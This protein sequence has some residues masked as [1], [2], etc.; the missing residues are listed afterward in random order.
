MIE[1]FRSAAKIRPLSDLLQ[2]MI[3]TTRYV[4]VLEGEN[5]LEAKA[6][7][8]NIR[9]FLI[10]VKEFEESLKGHEPCAVLQAYLEFISLQTQI[11]EWYEGDQIFTLMTLHSAKGLEFPVVFMLGVEE[12]LLPHINAMNASVDEIEEERRLCY[13]GFTR[14]K[15]RLY[16]SYAVSRRM[17]G[18]TKRQHPSR[19]LYEIPSKLLNRPPD[20]FFASTSVE[21]GDDD[22]W[23]GKIKTA[24]GYY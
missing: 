10:S 19:F 14:A 21:Y 22:G 8:E 12:G 15:E 13:V 1:D 9:E 4:V 2:S 6:R 17:F 3:D 7:V 11:D 20:Y 18:Y 24:P 5:T 23:E 16:L